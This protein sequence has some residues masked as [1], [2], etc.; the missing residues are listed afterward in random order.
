MAKPKTAEPKIRYVDIPE[1]PE[2][3]ADTVETFVFDGVTF[4]CVFSVTRL[5]R[6]KPPS[7]AS[8]KR[9]PACRLVLTPEAAQ[10]LY[11]QLSSLAAAIEQSR[12][13]QQA[14]KGPASVQ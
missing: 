8:G 12:K 7:R 13:M 1:L 11:G 6:P 5:D 9:Y 10:N 3:F 2:T 4:R 14:Q